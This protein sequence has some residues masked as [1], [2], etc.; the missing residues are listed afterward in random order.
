[1]LKYV[2]IILINT[3]NRNDTYKYKYYKL[4]LNQIN[5]I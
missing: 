3:Y 1:M 4:K 5:S 2:K